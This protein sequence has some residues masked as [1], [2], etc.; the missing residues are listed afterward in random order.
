MDALSSLE[1]L[2]EDLQEVVV[3]PKVGWVAWLSV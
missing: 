2:Q 3:L 1:D